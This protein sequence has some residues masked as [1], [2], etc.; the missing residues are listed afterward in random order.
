M[1]T[2]ILATGNAHKAVEVRQILEGLDVEV[3]TLKDIG[4]DPEIVEDG[5]SFEENALIKARAVYALTGCAV[6]AD[7]S[8][9]EIA[10]FEGGPGVYSSRF[11][12]E[13]TDYNVKNAI[14]LDRLKGAEG[15]ERAADYRCVIALVLPPDKE[16]GTAREITEEGRVDGLIARE[17]AG[18]G[19]FGYDPIFEVPEYGCSMAELSAQQKNAIS[20]RGNALK[21]VRPHIEKWLG[22]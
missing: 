9:I 3:K 17:P 8:G 18:E 19:G 4:L 21:A 5:I 10:A 11:L 15:E 13:D 1:K 12:G 6:M 16:C 2:I 20:H 14:I 22:E 7:D